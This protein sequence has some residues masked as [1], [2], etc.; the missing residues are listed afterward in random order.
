MHHNHSKSIYFKLF[1]QSCSKDENYTNQ[2]SDNDKTHLIFSSDNIIN[3]K[4]FI[5]I[6][7]EQKIKYINIFKI[8]LQLFNH[9]FILLII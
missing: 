3:I 7:K 5:F 4:I 1:V 6:V 2:N 8:I 9:I